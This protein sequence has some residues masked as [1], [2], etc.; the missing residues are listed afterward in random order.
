MRCIWQKTA[1]ATVYTT[2]PNSFL[3]HETAYLHHDAVALLRVFRLHKLRFK[4]EWATIPAD[5]PSNLIV[6]FQDKNEINQV[7]RP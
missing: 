2:L 6:R 7:R 5:V 3:A 4:V 1:G